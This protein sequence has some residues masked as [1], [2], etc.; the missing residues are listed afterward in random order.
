MFRSVDLAFMEAENVRRSAAR[1]GRPALHPLAEYYGDWER[2]R[3]TAKEPTNERVVGVSLI[4][5]D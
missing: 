3:D 4:G 5:E 2:M 1:A